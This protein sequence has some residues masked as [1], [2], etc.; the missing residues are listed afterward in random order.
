[1]LLVILLYSMLGL[2]VILSKILLA[3]ASPLFLVGT[4]MLI[5]G[6]LLSGYAALMHRGHQKLVWADWILL[7]QFTI[8]G[9]IIPHVSR[10]W[11]LQYL[12]PVKTALFFNLVPFFSALFGYLLIKERL[13][14]KQ[15][16]GLVIGFLGTLPLLLNASSTTSVTKTFLYTAIP[17]LILLGAVASLSYSFFVMQKLVRHRQHSPILANGF[18]MFLGGFLSVN[19]AAITEPVWVKQNVILFIALL[20]LNIVI[21]NFLCANLHAW[22]LKKHSATFISFASFLS[23]LFAAI[24][25]WILFNEH[26]SYNFVTAFVLVITGLF[27]YFHDNLR[28]QRFL[29]T[30]IR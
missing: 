3:Y 9:V 29:P 20:I 7:V 1:M 10:T 15:M 8:F 24:Y 11:A 14:I 6:I 21:S 25:S 5:S 4:R 2:T 23:P 27:V 18:S 19:A 16:I 12:S 17:E 22:L 26:I 30:F 13:S 28:D